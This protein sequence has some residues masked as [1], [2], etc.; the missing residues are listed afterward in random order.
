MSNLH[1]VYV[2]M[3]VVAERRSLSIV[4]LATYQGKLA[5]V[6][7]VAHALAHQL[8]DPVVPGPTSCLAPHSSTTTGRLASRFVRSDA[9]T[10][11]PYTF[12]KDVHLY[13]LTDLRQ[14]PC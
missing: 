10:A 11:R 6:E 12:K 2:A 8:E 9:A 13:K 1:N 14:S 7:G 3:Q 4:M 5:I